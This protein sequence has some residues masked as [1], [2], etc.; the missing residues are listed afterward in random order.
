VPETEK[1]GSL[2]SPRERQIADRYAEGLSYKAIARA[3]DIAPATVRTHLG[4]V[5]R[6]LGVTSKIELARALADE[7][8]PLPR[9]PV[10]HERIIADLALE[11]DEAIRRE[12]V[13]AHVL[14]IISRSG[15]SLDAVID[16][17]LEHALD[18][19]DA[20]FGIL[21]DH[22]GEGRY[23]AAQSRNIAPAFAA[24]LEDQDVFPADPATGLGRVAAT[25]QVINI[26]DVR[27][28][29]IYRTG[30]PLRI[31]TADLGRARSFAAIPMLSGDRLLGAFTVYRAR[32]HPFDAR[33][34]ELAQLFAD[35]AAIAIENARSR[36]R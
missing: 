17:V 30:A 29:D 12:R 26:F 36:A 19:C 7:A 14:S 31:A 28:E 3:F 8:E 23:R 1:P 5:Y 34:L 11:L 20:Q 18:I 32:V 9:S 4:T 24:W 22:L 10:D 33:V 21:F 25:R 16:A 15:R 27:G 6:K 13:L 35:Q 2:L